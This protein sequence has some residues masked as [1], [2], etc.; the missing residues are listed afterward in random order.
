[1]SAM[2]FAPR[3]T[4]Q[5]F[6]IVVLTYSGETVKMCAN[7]TYIMMTLNRY[8]LVGKDHTQWLVSLAK[9]EF[10]W[11]IR[12]SLLLTALINIGH[13]FEY[14]ITKLS[15]LP[16]TYVYSSQED[17]VFL[18]QF[19]KTY[20]SQYPSVSTDP[21]F[22]VYSVVYFIINFLFFF[23][24]NTLI[25]IQIVRRMHKELEDKRARMAKMRSSIPLTSIS[26][27]ENKNASSES[28]DDKKERRVIIMVV[29][30]GIINFVL[31]F[32]DFLIFLEETNNASIDYLNSLYPG[33]DGLLLDISYL[34]YILTFSFTVLLYY[35]FNAKFKEAF[36]LFPGKKPSTTH[37]H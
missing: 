22:F 27:T 36:V 3:S 8:L 4:A 5:Y 21:S 33:F 12:G 31:R 11:V 10:K 9:A 18:K 17:N 2:P 7:I 25:E 28:E 35:N 30:N 23:I 16:P 14:E 15:N 13:G 1:M 26:A 37:K 20:I 24:V 34:A 6:K 32:P 19:Q 29:L